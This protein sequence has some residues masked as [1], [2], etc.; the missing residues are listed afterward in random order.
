MERLLTGAYRRPIPAEHEPLARRLLELSHSYQP[1]ELRAISPVL[2]DRLVLSEL[3]PQ[4]RV[5]SLDSTPRFNPEMADWTLYQVW[6]HQLGRDRADT[7]SSGG[8]ANHGGTIE[9]RERRTRV[10]TVLT[11]H[12][13]VIRLSKHDWQDA[14]DA[15]RHMRNGAN[16]SLAPS[17]TPLD[18]FITD[19]P[20]LKTGHERVSA[21]IT[22]TKQ[23]QEHARFLDLTT[24]SP[25]DL[26]FKPSDKRDTSRSRRGVPFSEQDAE[27]IFSGYIYQGPLPSERTK[28]YPFWFWLPL[29]GYFTGARTNEIAQLDTA[30]IKIVAGHP[31]IDF[32]ADDVNAFEA[33]RIKTDEARIVISI[34]TL[35]SLASLIML[36]ISGKLTR[37]NCLATASLTWATEKKRLHTIRKAGPRARVSFSM[38]LQRVI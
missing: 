34:P 37:K 2:R 3:S 29:V 16:A 15:A 28:A 25:N 14:Y 30:D 35:L 22:S 12:K 10:M 24:V 31:C 33:K 19:D 38:C 4:S 8:Q 7:S 18:E 9:E 26:L 27:A 20:E 1:T 36:L 21:L 17:P 11:Q 32:C 13:A 23:I 6:R 5:S